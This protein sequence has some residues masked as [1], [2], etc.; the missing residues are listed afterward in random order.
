[1]RSNW[2]SA[3]GWNSGADS[4]AGSAVVLSAVVSSAVVVVGSS[5]PVVVVA[6][7]VDVVDDG[8][9]P[10]VG[11]GSSA[12][13]PDAGTVVPA[14][15]PLSP[16][17]LVGW[18]VS[19]LQAVPKVRAISTGA[20]I[21]VV[22]AIERTTK[23]GRR[24][25]CQ[26]GRLRPRAAAS[27]G[28]VVGTTWPSVGQVVRAPAGLAGGGEAWMMGAMLRAVVGVLGVAVIGALAGACRMEAMD[29]EGPPEPEGTQAAQ[30][31]GGPASTAQTQRPGPATT[32]RTPHGDAGHRR[33]RRRAGRG[34]AVHGDHGGAQQ[35]ARGARAAGAGVDAGAGE[36]A[37]AWADKL[38][39]RGCELQH[40]PSRG[41]DAQKYGENIYW[42]SGKK[43]SVDEVVGDWVA[44]RK[45][46]NARTNGCKG[47]CGHYTQVVWRKS[48]R[49]GCGMATCGDAEVWVCNYDPPGNFMGERPF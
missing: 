12:V 28:Q 11:A 1:M 21:Q 26:D 7:V 47:V 32:P 43:S 18:A 34:R 14:V 4:S 25:R 40:R 41:A 33:G 8:G 30:P 10:V 5:G 44:E 23:A 19:S 37:Q 16:V 20:G 48:V 3:P 17:S 29:L 42:A 45:N 31:D 15:A 36:F 46:F 49:L 24:P 13:V 27:P 38:Q 35:G 6:G 39:K 9:S 2:A 22:R